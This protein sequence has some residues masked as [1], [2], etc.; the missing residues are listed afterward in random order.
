MIRCSIRNPKVCNKKHPSIMSKTIK[1][2]HLVLQNY[3]P[4]SSANKYINFHFSFWSQNIIP[5]SLDVSKNILPSE[6]WKLLYIGEMKWLAV[7]SSNCTG[8][9]CLTFAMMTGINRFLGWQH[10][11]TK[12]KLCEMDAW[13]SIPPR[14]EHLYP[15]L[16]N[17]SRA[18]EGVT[19][20]LNILRVL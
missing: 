20:V 14:A 11:Q 8:L 13:T 5:I 3:G 12:E 17:V 1:I 10:C 15:A 9:Y 18:Q 6:N 7:A 19:S 2:I 16:R 4:D